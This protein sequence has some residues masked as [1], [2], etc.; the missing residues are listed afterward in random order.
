LQ[1][2]LPPSALQV[3][4]THVPLFTKLHNLVQVKGWWQEGNRRSGVTQAMRHKLS[5][6]STYGLN[7]HRNGDEHPAYTPVGVWH[8]FISVNYSSAQ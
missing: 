7:S 3:V 1:V 6:L 4:H 2:Q 8:L 5:G